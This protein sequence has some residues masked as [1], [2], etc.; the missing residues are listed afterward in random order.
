MVFPYGKEDTDY[1]IDNDPNSGYVFNGA[2][3]V[4]W[5]RLRDLFSEEIDT[6]FNTKVSSDCFSASSLISQF[7]N[8]QDCFPEE[9]WRLDIQRKYLR[10]FLGTSVDNS[11]PKLDTQY[12]RNMM[13]GKKKY[14]RRQWVRDQ[15]SYFGTKHMMNTV[16]GDQNRITFRC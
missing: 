7:D 12:L 13:Q 16:V 2:T 10:T 1:N 5:C 6:M 4:F 9:I 14:Q 15:E 11:K 3:S 8:F